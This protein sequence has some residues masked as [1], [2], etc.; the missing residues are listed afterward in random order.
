MKMDEQEQTQETK[1]I[2]ILNLNI[3]YDLETGKIEVSGHI[4]NVATCT[5]MLIEAGHVIIKRSGENMRAQIQAA[6]QNGQGEDAPP[7]AVN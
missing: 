2:K 5:Q 3:S 6:K 4:D 1:Q 7:A